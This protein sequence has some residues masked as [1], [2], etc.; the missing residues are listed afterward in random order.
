MHNTETVILEYT[1][2]GSSL[3]FYLYTDYFYIWTL[4]VYINS[5]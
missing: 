4:L 3:I 1:V 2:Q 5:F